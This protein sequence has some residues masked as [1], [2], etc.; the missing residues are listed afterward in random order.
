MTTSHP[1]PP[2]ALSAAQACA[3]ARQVL[4]SVTQAV[5]GNPEE[6]EPSWLVCWREAMSSWRTTQGWARP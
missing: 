4:D 6:L 1:T 3:L 2:Q 5:V